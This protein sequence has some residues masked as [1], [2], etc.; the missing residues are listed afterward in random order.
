MKHVVASLTIGACLLL[1]PA[2]VVF[3]ADPHDV[4]LAPGQPG[5]ASAGAAIQCANF[6]ATPGAAGSNPNSPFGNS[7]KAYAGAGAGKSGTASAHAA[8]EYDVA[9]YQQSVNQMP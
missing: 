5:T 2:G 7:N 3:A 1:P 8:S 9:C 6:A 4:T